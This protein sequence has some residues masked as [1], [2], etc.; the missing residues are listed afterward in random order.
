METFQ[1]RTYLTTALY[2]DAAAQLAL[3]RR[4]ESLAFNLANAN[5]TGFL[6]EGLKF[7]SVVSTTGGGNVAFPHAG[8]DYISLM[9]GAPHKTGNP[10]DVAIRGDVWLS[11][12]TPAGPAY[13]RDGRLQIDSGGAIRSIN[14]YPLLDAGGAPLSVDASAGELSIA[15]DGAIS[16]RGKAVGALGLFTLDADARLS[17]HDNSSILSDREA[18]PVAASSRS[19]LMQGFLEQSNV[20]PLTELTKMIE[21]QR[22]FDHISACMNMTDTAQQDAIRTLG[23]Q[24]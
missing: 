23:A 11:I 21:I 7:D 22:T 2:V 24:T 13:T 16:Q 19:G 17:R 4:M 3:T 1:R 8:A 9:R 5:T 20:A 12:M 14:G 10:L 6:G 15:A 18:T